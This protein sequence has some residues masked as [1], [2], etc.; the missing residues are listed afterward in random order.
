MVSERLG[1][2]ERGVHSLR[3]AA[4]A[5]LPE[6][7]LA[8]VAA[9][10]TVWGH[11]AVATADV[12]DAVVEAGTCVP[13]PALRTR[14]ALLQLGT[15]PRTSRT[16]SQLT[17]RPRHNFLGSCRPCHRCPRL[18][19]ALRSSSP[20]RPAAC[21]RLRPRG[22]HPWPRGSARDPTHAPQGRSRHA[23]AA[24]IA[25]DQGGAVGPTPPEHPASAAAARSPSWG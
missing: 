9:V 8:L 23:A 21:D 25:L 20:P 7:A 1:S 22:R 10:A 13:P 24:G 17:H 18:A 16:P 2:A 19:V 15:A 5:A 6:A 14:R 12:A 3:H 11:V 4:P